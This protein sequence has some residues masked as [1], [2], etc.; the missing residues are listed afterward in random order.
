MSK[1]GIVKLIRPDLAHFT[2]Y[3]ASKSPEEVAATAR[4]PINGVIKL[5]ANENPYGC[6]P[7]VM[8]AL[9][10]Y[11]SFNIYPDAGQR[12]LKKLLQGYTGVGAE[13]IVA[14]SGSDQMIGLITQLFVG[15]GDEV[16]NFPP[17][18]DIFRFA[19]ALCNGR[20]VDVL[21]DENY[22]VDIAAVK[23]AITKKTKLIVLA[24][25]N[26]PTGTPT[27]RKDILELLDTGLPVLA[28]EAYVEFSG[29][30]DTP[31]VPSYKNLM[32]L[33]TF[34]KWAGL[35]SFRIGYGIFPPEIADYLMNIKMPY[36]VSSASTIAVR[37]SLKDRDFLMERVE[38]IVAER[39]RLYGE[40]R[41]IEWLK[42]FPSKAN[43]IFC[44]VLNGTAKLIY[45]G[46]MDRSIIIRY[47]GNH[48]LKDAIRI[49]VGKPE[50][51]DMVIKA[52]RDVEA[53]RK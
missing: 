44:H 29:E 33:R 23:K 28:D 38:K 48:L 5:D 16:I 42:P 31:L 34:S 4:F 53:E 52:I 17:T 14:S 12:E 21:R 24:N 35:A 13:H 3:V 32:V 30:T 19:V 25:P 15:P 18:F 9:S 20:L 27:P 40:L 46:L 10:K 2:G 36:S 8:E 6:S 7:R 43:F 22:N 26:N 37:E 11:D 39:E 49:G 47:A 41:K 50:H 1:N 45:E 51:T